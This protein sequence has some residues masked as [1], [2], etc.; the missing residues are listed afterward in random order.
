MTCLDRGSAGP[1]EAALVVDDATCCGRLG[2]LEHFQRELGHVF[3]RPELLELA[4][5]HRSVTG[6]EA[7]DANNERLEYLG[8]AVIGFFTADALYHALGDYPEGV[9]SKIRSQIVGT[10]ALAA[11]AVQ[12]GVPHFIRAAPSTKKAGWARGMLAD[13]VEALMGA[14]YCDGQVRAARETFERLFGARL[15]LCVAEPERWSRPD[16][17][18]ALQELLQASGEPLPSYTRRSRDVSPTLGITVF[19]VDCFA[20]GHLYVGTG[21]NRRDAEQDAALRALYHLEE[22][23]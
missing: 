8:D 2:R 6:T 11:I 7:C 23:D 5:T 13:G 20:R 22:A 15:E 17:K 12:I 14:V 10:H 9:L 19:T 3:S 21:P 16:P 1:G 4:L 18:T